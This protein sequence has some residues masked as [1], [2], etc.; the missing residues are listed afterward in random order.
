MNMKNEQGTNTPVVPVARLLRAVEPEDTFDDFSSNSSGYSGLDSYADWIA[1]GSPVGALIE[2]PMDA[3]VLDEAMQI[4][5]KTEPNIVQK[6]ADAIESGSQFPPITLACI[7]GSLV[8]VDGWHR[9]YARQSLREAKV[10]AFVTAMSY[11]EALCTSALANLANG[12]PLKRGEVKDAFHSFMQN[13]G[14]RQGHKYLSY[15]EIA[16]KFGV[17]YTTIRNWVKKDYPRI[18][19]R[20][21]Q[22]EVKGD[23]KDWDGVPGSPGKRPSKADSLALEVVKQAQTAMKNTTNMRDRLCP[24][25]RGVL[26]EALR[27]TLQELEKLPYFLPEF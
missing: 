1:K 23:Y 19:K 21:Q 27:E 25:T 2:V 22:D 16:Q 15:R 8:L 14:Y 4:R 3:V 26:I 6:Y 13:Y 20:Y 18:F 12:V 9:F 7:E 10:V 11:E 5:K 17:H 24:D